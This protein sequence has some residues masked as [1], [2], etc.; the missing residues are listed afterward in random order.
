MPKPAGGT[1][2]Y[3]HVWRI[4]TDPGYSTFPAAGATT[5]GICS[6][7]SNT[8]KAACLA[9]GKSW[10]LVA[11][12]APDGEYKNAVWVD[13]DLAC[14]QCHGGG[15]TGSGA[16]SLSKDQLSDFAKGIHGV[17]RNPNTAPIAAMA[18]LPTVDGG[19]VS[20]QDK[21]TDVEDPQYSLRI[22]V[23]WGD[24]RIETGQ[25]GGTFQHTYRRA[26]TFTIRH[27][28][29]DTSGRTGYEAVKVTVVVP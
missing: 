15:V 21:S 27:K 1:G 25:A 18:A 4:N 7:P 20:F 5:P 12:S 6:D 17:S 23:S 16:K 14:G 28:A 29:T 26:G 10:S 3:V 8:T 24:G 11:N 19:V 22:A 9:A 2:L 13:L